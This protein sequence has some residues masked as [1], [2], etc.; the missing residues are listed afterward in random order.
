MP[1]Y[2][3]ACEVCGGRFERLSSWSAADAQRCPECA[4]PARR[5]ISAFASAGS[6]EPES[7]G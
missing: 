2:E 4:E 5:L 1:L 6:C 3:Y 7:G